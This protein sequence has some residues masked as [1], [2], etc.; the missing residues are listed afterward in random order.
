MQSTSKLTTAAILAA[1]GFAPATVAQ[2]EPGADAPAFEI[3]HGWN[4]APRT[5]AEMRGKVV[6]LEFMATW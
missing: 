4:G 1:A 5:F 3:R 6:L 2:W